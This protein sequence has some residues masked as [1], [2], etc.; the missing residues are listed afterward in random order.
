MHE[1]VTLLSSDKNGEN[2]STF[3]RHLQ[4]C[5]TV[6]TTITHGHE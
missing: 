3:E 2:T 1:T 4:Y 6:M 5:S